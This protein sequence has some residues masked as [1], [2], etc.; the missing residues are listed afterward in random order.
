MVQTEMSMKLSPWKCSSLL[1]VLVLG[2]YAL[3]GYFPSS[4]EVF[5]RKART[6]THPEVGEVRRYDLKDRGL[7]SVLFAKDGRSFVAATD[8]SIRLF[9][10]DSGEELR[11]YAGHT[12]T[13]QS[14]AFS[15]DHS[16]FASAGGSFRYK[17]VD[18]IKKNKLDDGEPVDC[19]LRLWDF[20]SGTQQMVFSGHT[21]R[22]WSV[23]V[24]DD[25]K[26]LVSASADGTVRIWDLQSGKEIR[27][28]IEG[29]GS[30]K[31]VA[32]R[33]DSRQ[34]ASG[35]KDGVIRLWDLQG[36]RISEIQS[37]MRWVECL[38]LLSNGSQILSG[39]GYV[40]G[41]SDR[42][43]GQA[44]DCKLRLF[45]VETKRQLREFDHGEEMICSLAVSPDDRWALTGTGSIAR[46][47]GCGGSIQLWELETGRRRAYF[48]NG[49][50]WVTTVCFSRDGK[51]ALSGDTG[52]TVKLWRLE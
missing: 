12:S 20:E 35:G 51:F 5:V 3:R 10:L 31:A 9:S 50:E 17:S 47:D 39:G 23:A 1:A 52:H 43:E 49:K 7:A 16:V 2:S 25:S 4:V 13:V 33:S 26:F 32:V 45:D 15:R 41:E 42:L 19:T 44:S 37:H 48:D 6:S 14:L 22:I 38:S 40:S 34:I 46:P 29:S 36:N 8:H 28:I 21:H 11:R 30:V 24:S 27:R 18:A